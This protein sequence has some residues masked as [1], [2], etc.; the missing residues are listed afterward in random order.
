MS[1]AA[2]IGLGLIA[3][4]AALWW[5]ATLLARHLQGLI[6]LLTRSSTASSASY[7]LVVLPGVVLHELAHIL[8]AVA[9]GVRV[10][11][12]DLF[13]FRR[14]GDPRQG[15]VIVERVDPFR[16]SLV[17]AGP[18]LAGVPAVLLL[19][20]WLHIPALGLTAA[21]LQELRPLLGEPWSLLRLYLLWAIANAMFPSAADRAAWWVVGG[22]A[23]VVGAIA[24]LTGY[25]PAL[26]SSISVRLLGGA[27][28]LT[29]GLLP[30]AAL[31]LVLL[32]V[33]A[34]LEWLAGRVTGRRVIRGR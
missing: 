21:A 11:R 2:S 4:L 33:V 26:P 22:A 23:L 32:V 17:G 14:A 27:A 1:D 20:R 34:G 16:M 9:L 3:V 7:D 19:L 30:V 5:L 15:E 10:I 6:L 31:D 8:V 13:R 18:L 25:W 29:S 24:A 12:A 28:R